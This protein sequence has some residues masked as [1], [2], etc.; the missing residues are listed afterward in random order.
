MR[1]D[2][3]TADHVL[4]SGI[5]VIVAGE[6]VVS[7]GDATKMFHAIGEAISEAF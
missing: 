2:K 3:K 4:I 6:F 7:G 1:R 5:K